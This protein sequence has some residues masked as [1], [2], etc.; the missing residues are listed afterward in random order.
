M[1]SEKNVKFQNVI[2]SLF[3]I[4]FSSFF[5]CSVG[6][7]CTLSFKIDSI[8][9]W[10][11]PL[12]HE[13]RDLQHFCLLRIQIIEVKTF[14]FDESAQYWNNSKFRITGSNKNWQKCDQWQPFL[15]RPE[16]CNVPAGI[17]SWWRICKLRYYCSINRALLGILCL[18]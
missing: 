2:S 15:K 3:L 16:F 10:I 8:L 17:P 4:Q 13:N 1:F 5:H 6:K 7:K 14:T 11:S 12:I 18:E 9:E